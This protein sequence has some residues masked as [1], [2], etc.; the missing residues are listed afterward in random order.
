[1]STVIAGYEIL[2]KLGQG[3]MGTV[4]RARQVAVDREVALKILVPIVAGDQA[5]AE[6]FLREARVMGAINHPNVLTIHD[7]GR[8]GHALYIALELMRG[9]DAEGLRQRSGGRVPITRALEIIRDATA[10]AAALH[11]AGLLHRDIKPANIFLA[12]NGDAK[13]A[14]LGLARAADGTDRMTAAGAAVGT[15]AYMAVE[16]ATGVADLDARADVYALGASLFTLA[17]GH[18]PYQGPTP[19]AVLAQVLQDPVPEPRDVPAAVRTVIMKA[20]AKDRAQR[21]PDAESLLAALESCLGTRGR[22]APAGGQRQAL[23][24]RRA[25]GRAWWPIPL[26][27]AG[28][29][30]LGA[31]VAVGLRGTQPPSPP[32]ETPSAVRA[33]VPTSPIATG[34]VPASSEPAAPAGKNPWQP[35]RL[36][37][38]GFDEDPS[39]IVG[40]DVSGPRVSMIPDGSTAGALRVVFHTNAEQVRL[41]QK[42]AV[43]PAWGEL[44]VACLVRTTLGVVRTDPS[45]YV[46]VEFRLVDPTGS[47][48]DAVWRTPDLTVPE[49]V[50][51]WTAARP[52]PGHA[53]PAGYG[54]LTLSLVIDDV[55]GI[56]DIDDVRLEARR[57]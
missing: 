17:V 45:A 54:S 25:R 49:P 32:P 2:S 4:Y 1:M 40:W 48:A 53:V 30:F 38:P 29:A 26:A 31:G 9:G 6:R 52:D 19:F 56:I 13:L 24:P 36:A 44:R 3:G 22:P 35:V 27:V 46:G 20:M 33:P 50:L 51:A 18:Q 8:D 21:Y 42:V 28:L 34:S 39:R 43:D 11:A 57:R 15:P 16:Q 37:N 5:L 41:T 47:R 7:A 55:K 12:A 23:R 14:D 10:G